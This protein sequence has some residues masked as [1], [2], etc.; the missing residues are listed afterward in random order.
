MYLL[1]TKV[2]FELYNVM[3]FM[4]KH[5]SGYYLEGDSRTT[6]GFYNGADEIDFYNPIP[7]CLRSFYLTIVFSDE[8]FC[9][10]ISVKTNPVQ[11]YTMYL[12]VIN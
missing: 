9:Y 8:T 6:C 5:F 3:S 10:K 4:L 12:K 2:L 7:V 11:K 1:A